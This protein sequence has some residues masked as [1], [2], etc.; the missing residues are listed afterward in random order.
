MIQTISDNTFRKYYLKKNLIK[1][2]I[3]LLREVMIKL[4]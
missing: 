1:V 3:N 4:V 2:G